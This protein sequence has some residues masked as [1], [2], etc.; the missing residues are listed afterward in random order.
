MR[1]G[2]RPDSLTKETSFIDTLIVKSSLPP[3]E[4]F[5]GR[6]AEFLWLLNV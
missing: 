2:E 4:R 3:M 6:Q 1:G 5:L